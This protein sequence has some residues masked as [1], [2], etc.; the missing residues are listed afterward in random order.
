MHRFRRIFTNPRRVRTTR[1]LATASAIALAAALLVA[2]G[3]GGDNDQ[4]GSGSDKL[5]VWSRGANETINKAFVDAWNADHDL[6]AEL[7]PGPDDEYDQ[8][9]AAAVAAGT[10]PDVVTVDV[11]RCPS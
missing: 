6:K 9:S 4:A 5:T 1:G 10:P 8:K 11:V 2:F 7:L 3:G